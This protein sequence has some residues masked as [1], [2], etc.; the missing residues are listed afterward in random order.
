VKTLVPHVLPY[1][2]YVGV[3]A[4]AELL[5]AW[6]D[7]V[8]VALV[9]AA[10][11]VFASRGAYAELRARPSAGAL[12]LGVVAGLVVGAAWVPLAKLVPPMSESAR[13]ALDPSSA[14]WLV[15][16]RI[17]AMVLVVPFAEELL[18]RSALPRFLDAKADED[19]RV[20]PVGAFTPLS[21]GVSIA[22]FTLTH[23]EW[24][25]A[26]ATALVWTAL[27]AK[28]RNLWTVIAAHVAANV[29]VVVHV[30]MTGEKQWW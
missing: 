28:T 7:V 9:V 3:G 4:A 25:A 6:T 10:L 5:G 27:L 23:P 20:R 16:A 1:A 30:L 14:T 24:L 2:L 12:L 13:T 18:V 17:A 21:A 11:V 26:L 19:W 15:A 29:W 22:F 8:R